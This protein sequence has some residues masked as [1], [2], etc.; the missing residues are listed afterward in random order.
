ESGFE[1]LTRQV[2][3]LKQKKLS[4]VDLS[5]FDCMQRLGLTHALAFD[6]HFDRQGFLTP[7]SQD[8]SYP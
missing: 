3:L 2:L 5:S 6:K 8:W 7:K 1:L 4:L